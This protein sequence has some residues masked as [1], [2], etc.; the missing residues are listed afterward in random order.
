MTAANRPKHVVILVENLP[1]PF[2]RRPWQIAQ[3]LRARGHKIS[4]GLSLTK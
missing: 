3:T 1:V 2:D 4:I